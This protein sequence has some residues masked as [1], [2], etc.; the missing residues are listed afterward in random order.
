MKDFDVILG[1]DWLHSC[2][3]C[4]DCH[5][6][7]DIFLFPNE[8]ELVWE[9]YN[10]SRPNALISH[11]KANKMMS[12]GLLCHLVS[13]NDLDHDIHSIDSIPIV[14]EFPDMFPVDLPGVTA[15]REIDSG[16]DLEPDTKKISI[17]PYI[18]S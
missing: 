17:S 11:P 4:M 1:M 12:K 16:I 5:S 9:G 7:V 6:R 3:D 13:V 2:Y 18:M 15:P 8:V 10:S 14:N